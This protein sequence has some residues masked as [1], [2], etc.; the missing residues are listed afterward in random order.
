MLPVEPIP[1]EDAIHRQIDFPRMYNNAR[2][3]IWEDVFQFPGQEPESVVW[4]KY[5]PTA[6]HV[7]RIGRDREVKTR[8]RNPDSRYIGFITSTAG[9]VRRIRTSP[10]HGFSVLHA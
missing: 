6:D 7:H 8:E 1:D 10:G 9:A 2:E 4:N 3:M 5:A